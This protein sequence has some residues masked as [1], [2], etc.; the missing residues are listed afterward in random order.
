M[1]QSSRDLVQYLSS[2]CVSFLAGA[3]HGGRA[4]T[5][6]LYART[7]AF[8][9][10]LFSAADPSLSDEKLRGV[11]VRL[12]GESF[13][14]LAYLDRVDVSSLGASGSC[15]AIAACS[16]AF[17]PKV[18]THLGRGRGQASGG[19]GVPSTAAR[20]RARERERASEWR[21]KGARKREAKGRERSRGQPQQ[22]VRMESP[23]E[24]IF[25]KYPLFWR[26]D[27]I[28]WLGEDGTKRSAAEWSRR[29]SRGLG[30]PLSPRPARLLDVIPPAIFWSGHVYSVALCCCL[31]GLH[32]VP[33]GDRAAARGG[34]HV[35][36]GRP[37]RRPAH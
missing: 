26:W 5:H 25:A 19:V 7:H 3:V 36:G 13:P 18:P 31:A 22:A 12:E 15:M 10:A 8:S 28:I 11:H 6:A 21:M 29:I 20:A 23:R 27:R 33:R 35:R 2:S 4:R 30:L 37:L 32:S 17:F 9:L 1:I 34:V 16:L 24:R 14:L